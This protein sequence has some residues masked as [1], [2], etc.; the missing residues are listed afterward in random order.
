MPLY[1]FGVMISFFAVFAS[2]LVLVS[3]I[4][5]RLPDSA[6]SGSSQLDVPTAAV[7]TAPPTPAPLIGGATLGGTPD[8]FQSALGAPVSYLTWSVAIGGQPASVQ[9]HVAQGSDGVS[10]ATIITISPPPD[11]LT[12]QTWDLAALRDYALRFLPPDAQDTGT[13]VGPHDTPVHDLGSRLLAASLP[14]SVF[15]NDAGTR[16]VAPGSLNWLCFLNGQPSSRVN[17]CFLSVGTYN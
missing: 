5:P 15:T 9:V 13:E 6:L 1:I 7:S 17:E 12:S 10:R 3:A 14:A 4:T 11:R 8:A 16:S 2:M